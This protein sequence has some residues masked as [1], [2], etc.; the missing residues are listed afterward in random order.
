[1]IIFNLFKVVIFKLFIYL[2]LLGE[3]IG[4]A[5]RVYPYPI[6]HD[7]RKAIHE[8]DTIRFRVLFFKHDT[9]TTRY[10]RKLPVNTC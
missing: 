3:I 5:Y 9:N 10:T 7:I 8:H 1:M 6:R 2:V 4:L